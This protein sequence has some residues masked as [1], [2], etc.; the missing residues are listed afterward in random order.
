L[1][2]QCAHD[3]AFNTPATRARR[4]QARQSTAFD[5][6]PIADRM[7]ARFSVLQCQQPAANG[8]ADARV[9]V[10][11]AGALLRLSC[12]AA[13]GVAAAAEPVHAQFA[14]RWH[15]TGRAADTLRIA[16]VL[17]ADHELNASSF[18]ARCVAST[19]ADLGKAVVGGLAS[20]SGG[21]HGGM[22]ER[23]EALWDEFERASTFRVGLERRLSRGDALVGFGH[24]L[25]PDGDPRAREILT[26]LPAGAVK[27][28]ALRMVAHV[29]ELTGKR[30]ALDFAL[31]ALRRAI[32]APEGGAY[33][34]FAVGR[35]VGWLAHALEQRTDG[36]LIRPRAAY[37]GRRPSA[38]AASLDPIVMA[39]PFGR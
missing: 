3:D 11:H 2:W 16:L 8:P 20:L 32:G 29:A 10:R 13:L 37:T 33:A 14:A 7:L 1:L 35:T 31:V 22:T 27:N 21:L 15:L 6:A 23:V 28:A 18:V 5:S 12:A 36:A 26:R 19:G 38:D 39:S 17:S 34:V 9:L 4:V 24:P 30:P 25:Y